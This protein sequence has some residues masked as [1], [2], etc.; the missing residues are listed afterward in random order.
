MAGP[1]P[2]S[3]DA[4]DTAPTLDSVTVGAAL[5]EVAE[6]ELRLT[7]NQAQFLSIASHELRT[8]LTS[9]AAFT[10]MFADEGTPADQRAQ[11]VAAVQRNVNRMLVLIED[12]HLLSRLVSADLVPVPTEID[13]PALLGT[14]TEVLRERLPHTE[15][16]LTVGTGP[17]VHGDEELLSYLLY[18]VV[19]V[20]GVQS[21]DQRVLVHAAADPTGWSVDA[22]TST[23]EPVSEEHLFTSELSTLERKPRPRSTALWILIADAIA[24]CHGGS[25]TARVEDDSRATTR[26]WLPFSPPI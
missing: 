2:A 23:G 14:V 13:L 11:A 6:R 20:L 25:F 19:G 21:A 22:S 15:L 8:P 26:A 1:R 24:R 5:R 9:I 12:L 16:R 4:G 10:D 18:A 7:E 17:I 3:E